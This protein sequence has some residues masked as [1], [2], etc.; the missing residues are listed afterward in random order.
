MSVR[1]RFGFPTAETVVVTGG[2]VILSVVA[3][4]DSSPYMLGAVRKHF[5]GIVA[6]KITHPVKKKISS[7]LQVK[8]KG[9]EGHAASERWNQDFSLM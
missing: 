1:C 2:V 9:L 5:T 4:A 3:A 8:T 7:F 6:F